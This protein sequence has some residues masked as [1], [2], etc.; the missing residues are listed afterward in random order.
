MNP[1]YPPGFLGLQ[2]VGAKTLNKGQGA[3][4]MLLNKS[5]VKEN[6]N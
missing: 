2:N 6:A 4:V 5:E 3:Q 1:T